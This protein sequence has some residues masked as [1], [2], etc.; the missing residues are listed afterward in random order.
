MNRKS[1]EFWWSLPINGIERK[2]FIVPK[3]VAYYEKNSSFDK[4]KIVTWKDVHKKRTEK[5][6]S[7]VDRK[8]KQNVIEEKTCVI[9]V[10]S[11]GYWM[12]GGYY[13]VI[14]TVRKQYYLNFRGE[15]LGTTSKELREKV[16]SLFPIVL[17]IDDL[18]Y[19][20]MYEF[21]KIYNNQKFYKGW[22]NQ[23]IA[24]ARCKIDS[25]GN[26]VDIIPSN[27]KRVTHN[28]QI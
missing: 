27:P 10:F 24:F 18:F 25:Y 5:I 22:K 16:M 26:L 14:K 6:L 7:D 28:P 2:K 9:W 11:H 13:C 20:W 15:G 19:E 8:K 1:A 12:M 17:P 21:S 4:W 3:E 23:G